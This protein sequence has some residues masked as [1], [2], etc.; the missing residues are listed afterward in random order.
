MRLPIYVAAAGLCVVLTLFGLARSWPDHLGLAAIVIGAVSAV[1]VLIRVGIPRGVNGQLTVLRWFWNGVPRYAR[2][3]WLL[4]SLG[5]M[6]THV[7]VFTESRFREG[8]PGELLSVS[9]VYFATTA[10]MMA[11]AN[12]RVGPPTSPRAFT[13]VSVT[14]QRHAVRDIGDYWAYRWYLIGFRTVLGSFAVA[15]GF[16]LLLGCTQWRPLLV[17]V[18]WGPGSS[19]SAG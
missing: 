1:S 9:G 17:P 18:S 10:A 14:R 7:W 13:K 4:V 5:A 16:G 11:W 8:L 19:S 15:V 2:A 12:V 6:A 3:M